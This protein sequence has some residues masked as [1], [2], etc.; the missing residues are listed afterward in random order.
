MP[1]R[2]ATFRVNAP[3]GEL[4]KFIR[5]FEALCTCIPGVERIQVLDDRNA[6]LTVKEKIG[7][8]P[9]TLT[10]R[11]SIESEDPPHALHAVA[12]ADHLMME[13]DVRLRADGSGTETGQ[14]VRREG[15]GTAQ[16]HRR[17]PVR[18]QGD[19]ADRAVRRLPA[20]AVRGGGSPA[21]GGSAAG[22][23]SMVRPLLAAPAGMVRAA[24]V[25]GH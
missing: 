2:E 3:I 6:E 12:K 9:M 22:A 23:P 14:R 18:A 25:S 20:E 17:Q 4:W 1:R 7:V 11:A 21:R 5:D 13:I 19:R 24:R 10:L 16:G 8:V 15:G